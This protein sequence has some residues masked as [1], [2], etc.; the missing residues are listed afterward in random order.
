M[1]REVTNKYYSGYHK[2]KEEINQKTPGKRFGKVN[3]NSRFHIQTEEHDGRHKTEP[4]CSDGQFSREENN[5][6]QFDSVSNS[7]RF[8]TAS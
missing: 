6:I 5:S 8:G 2:A 3:V 7:I 1:Q 4:D